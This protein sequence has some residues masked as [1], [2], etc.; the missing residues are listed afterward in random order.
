MADIEISLL[1]KHNTIPLRFADA[2]ELTL[3]AEAAIEALLRRLPSLENTIE[4]A[5]YQFY[6]ELSEYRLKHNYQVDMPFASDNKALLPF[7]HLLKIFLPDEIEEGRFGLAFSCDWEE[8]HGFG[9]QF[10]DWQIVEVGGYA[11][12]FEFD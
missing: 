3:E 8:E 9:L 5:A 10:R 4:E 2:D 6:T 7:Y 1:Q 11:Q 12:A